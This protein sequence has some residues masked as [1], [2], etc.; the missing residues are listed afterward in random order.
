MNISH[1]DT[2]IAPHPIDPA[3]S[4]V[5]ECQ[6]RFAKVQDY[7]AVFLKQEMVGRTLLPQQFMEAKFRE[8]PRSVYLKWMQPDEGREVIYVEGQNNDKLVT[9]VTGIAKALTGTLMLD[10]DS[11]TARKGHR[12]S[13]REAGI[14]NMIEKLIVHWEFERQYNQT[15]VDITH[16]KLNG[17]PCFLIN[18][19]HPYPDEGKFMYHTCKVFIDKQLVLPIRIEGYAY[20]Q[21]V[22]KT[23]GPL[24]ECYTYANLQ[25]NVGLSDIDFSA[26][27]PHYGYSRF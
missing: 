23:P 11:P 17:R 8:Q 18:S 24:L 4:L 6:E 20:P 7:T 12:H 27:N 21:Q 13:I 19:A 2:E 1:G 16:V 5:R 14:G 26:D 10:P 25:V 15:V 3:L 9:H 22:G